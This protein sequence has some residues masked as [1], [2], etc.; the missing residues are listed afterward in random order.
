MKNKIEKLPKSYRE[1]GEG[2]YIYRPTIDEITGKINQIID[3]LEGEEECEDSPCHHCPYF[4]NDCKKC[5]SSDLVSKKEVTKAI[6]ELKRL[7]DD[8]EIN[9]NLDWEHGYKM[10]LVD[11][12]SKLEALNK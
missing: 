11:L 1:E 9:G 7:V 4:I 5:H 6:K 8:G 3:S 2:Q 12:K 10:A